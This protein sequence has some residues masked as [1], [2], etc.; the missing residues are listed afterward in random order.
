MLAKD[1]ESYFREFT[2]SPKDLVQTA[3]Q[4]AYKVN[5]KLY[6]LIWDLLYTRLVLCWPET[7]NERQKTW[8]G[9]KVD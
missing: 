7:R 4:G 3:K 2:G 6:M 9:S 1:N 5:A 8:H